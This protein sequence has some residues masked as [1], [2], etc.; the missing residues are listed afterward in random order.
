MNMQTIPTR[1]ELVAR[2]EAMREHLSATAL[3]TN[4]ARRLPDETIQA[5]QDAGFFKILQPKR[6]GGYE[7]H[8]SVFFDVQIAIASACPSSAWVLGVVAVHNW[9]LALFDDRAQQDVWGEDPSTLVSSSYMPVGKVERVEGGLKLSGRWS[10][11]SGSEHCQWAFLGAFVPPPEGAP[12]GPPDMRTFLVP[13]SDY[14]I[15]DVWHTTGLSG[16]GSQDIVV[17]GALVPEYRTHTFGDAFKLDSPGN[18]LNTAPLYRVPFGQIFVRSVSTPAIGMALGAL[19]SFT[20]TAKARVSQA[21]GQK[22]TENISTLEVTARAASAIEET[23]AVLHRNME[24]LMGY[25]E[26]GAKPPLETRVRFRYDSTNAV[27]RCLEAVDALFTCSG[28]R[29]IFVDNPINRFWQDIHACRAHF[30]NNPDKPGRNWGG[31]QLG[32]RN[33][34]FFI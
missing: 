29:A 22:V 30:A 25:A 10:F 23:R 15:V 20:D 32:M 13:R 12:K 7:H 19:G 16:T 24:Q 34:D 11:S 26:S 18:V 3:A 9:Q 6:F 17:D 4:A 8:P 5:F 27:Q 1:D 2:A 21:T 28:G 33:T 14:E 31:V